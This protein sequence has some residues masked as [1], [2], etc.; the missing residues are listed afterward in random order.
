MRGRIE[1][2]DAFP[3]SGDVRG[4]RVVL[5]GA[6][7]GLGELLAHAFSRAG[8]HVALVARTE[9]EIRAVADALHGP[10]LLF[11]GDVRDAE[12]NEMVADATVA[13]WSGLDVWM[14]EAGIS[15][16]LAG[17]VTTDPS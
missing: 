14:G 8:A 17:P 4:K 16:I 2:P 6:G 1:I 10:T 7:R 9:R 15:P 3:A 13:E 11:S 5:T 12:F